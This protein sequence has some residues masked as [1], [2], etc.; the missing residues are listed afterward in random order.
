[1]TDDRPER[2]PER[3]PLGMAAAQS[4]KHLRHARRRSGEEGKA[5]MRQLEVILVIAVQAGLAA[6]LATLIAQ[7]LFGSGMHVFAPAAAVATIA[8][9]IGQR[10]RRTFELLGGVGLGI[11]IG[12]LLRYF[13]GIG[14]WQTGLVVGLAIAT[15]LLVAGRGGALVGQ[16][17]GTAVLIS[18]LTP[19]EGNLE[20]PR[21]F[22]ALIG[23]GI[24]LVV[25]VL[26][27]PVNPIRVLDRAASPVFSAIA[28]QLGE[29][30]VALRQRDADR[31]IRSLERVR[32]LEADIG[33]LNEALSGAEEV[34][35]L[36]P[37][38]WHRRTQFH[39]YARSLTHIE[40]LVLNVRVM[41]RRSATAIQYK[42]PIPDELPGAFVRL[43]ESVLKMREECRLDQSPERTRALILEAADLAGRAWAQGVHSFGDT[44]TTD[45]RASA[46]DLLRATGYEPAEANR[47]VRTAAG[48]GQRSIRPLVRR[49][50]HRAAKRNFSTRDARLSRRASLRTSNRARRT[51]STGR[52]RRGSPAR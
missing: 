12:D 50:L 13:L 43:S 26:L 29:I 41:A 35:T 34:V 49:R 51:R 18:T 31:S 2:E 8:S 30:G 17:G 9:A 14:A 7:K 15:A 6:A 5:R 28:D 4:G 22:D 45:L 39:R 20:L 36:A 32:G 19:M 46:S 16:A 11:V 27:L 21:I 10:A 33:R 42:E 23:G 38:R 48:A 24:G 44:L 40:R 47:L 1:M 37:A 52:P 3:S 25:V